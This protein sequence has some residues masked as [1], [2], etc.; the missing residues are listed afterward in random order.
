MTPQSIYQ[1]PW[2]LPTLA[3]VATPF[4]LH[5]A[6]DVRG[7][8]RVWATI[9]A[10]TTAL[11]AWLTGPL[12]PVPASSA[13]GTVASVAFVII[14]D[15]RFFVLA[16]WLRRGGSARAAWLRGGAW[17]LVTPLLSEVL[18][19]AFPAIAAVERRTYLAYE[20]TF[21]AVCAAF[22]AA[23]TLGVRKSDRAEQRDAQAAVV[24][25]PAVHWPVVHWPVVLFV[26][27]Y[28]LWALAD[29]LLLAGQDLAYLLRVIPN[30]M[31][32]ALFMPLSLRRVAAMSLGSPLSRASEVQ[33]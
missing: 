7:A 12:S 10:C 31:Y 28:V 33:P 13:L 1:S 14:G 9:F 30:I 26:A 8:M 3:W 24:P 22:V 19:R 32:Y 25:G 4:V 6:A 16:T 18:R 20:L 17:S 29:V 2:V 27:Q 23:E 11:D 15:A 21:L 5:L